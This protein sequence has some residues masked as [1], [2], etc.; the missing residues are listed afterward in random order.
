MDFKTFFHELITIKMKDL[1][2]N[3]NLFLW[4]RKI[5][6]CQL[7]HLI[8]YVTFCYFCLFYVRDIKA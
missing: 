1:T 3:L 8:Y 2:Y 6:H 5:M 4:E 7:R